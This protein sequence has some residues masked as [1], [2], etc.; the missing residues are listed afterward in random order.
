M[1]DNDF[2]PLSIE[3]LNI[4]NDPAHSGEWMVSAV[5]EILELRKDRERMDW[6]EKHGGCAC[7]EVRRSDVDAAIE[8]M[9]SREATR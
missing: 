2:P 8:R 1:S 9:K 7:G 6:L 3:C 4:L 5:R